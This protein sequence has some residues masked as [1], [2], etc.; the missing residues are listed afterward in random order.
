MS[1]FFPLSPSGNGI[2]DDPLKGLEAERRADRELGV[3]LGV[4]KRAYTEDKKNLLRDLNINV[5]KGDGPSARSL[6]ERL[7]VTVNRKGRI[8][9]AELDGVRIIVQRGKKLVFTEDVKKVQAQRIQQP[10]KESTRRTQ[11][12]PG[13]VD[14]GNPRRDRRREPRRL[15]PE[16]LPRKTERR[17][18]RE[19]RRDCRGTN[20]E[21]APGILGNTGRKASYRR[22]TEVGR[23]N[24]GREDQRTKDRGNSLEGGG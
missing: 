14:G 17:D 18:F 24:R 13:G 10:S 5:N 8:N 19:S 3:G 11:Y 20:G 4:K 6:L 9:G 16:E 12:H 1:F 7:K 2:F 21:Q 22:K 15:R 23:D